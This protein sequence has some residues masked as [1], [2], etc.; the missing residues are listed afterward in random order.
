MTV[1]VTCVAD[2]VVFQPVEIGARVATMA[3]VIGVFATTVRNLAGALATAALAW[4]FV[5]GFL[6]N[7]DGELT[8]ARPED[9]A[10]FGVLVGAALAGTACRALRDLYRRS[11]RTRGPARVRD[12]MRRPPVLAGRLHGRNTSVRGFGPKP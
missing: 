1:I 11:R 3:I 7:T 8:F 12:S 5:T 2:A 4:L 9:V 6:V 10:R